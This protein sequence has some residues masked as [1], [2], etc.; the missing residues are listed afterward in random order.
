MLKQIYEGFKV[1]KDFEKLLK[2]ID[3]NA[4]CVIASVK[5]NGVILDAYRDKCL[6]HRKEKH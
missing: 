4:E 1:A 6:N 2:E 3:N 5:A